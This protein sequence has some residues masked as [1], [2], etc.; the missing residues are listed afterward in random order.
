MDPQTFRPHDMMHPDKYT[1]RPNERFNPYDPA[2][3]RSILRQHNT[4]AIELLNHMNKDRLA[5]PNATTALSTSPAKRKIWVVAAL[6]TLGFV[7]EAQR[8][9]APVLLQLT[10]KAIEQL[11][12]LRKYL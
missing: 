10:P 7:V 2:G 8:P 3:A 9:D 5:Y 1:P 6:K 12:A 11:E 4:A